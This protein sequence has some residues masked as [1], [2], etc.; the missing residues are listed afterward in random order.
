MFDVD[1]KSV[2]YSSARDDVP[3]GQKLRELAKQGRRFG[4]RCLHILLRR[5]GVTINRKKA[6]RIYQEEGLDAA[7]GEAWEDRCGPFSA[8]RLRFG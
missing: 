8:S 3:V 6:Q 2:R 4:D 7:A 1:G 5:E